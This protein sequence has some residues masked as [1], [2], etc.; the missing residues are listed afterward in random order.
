MR[1]VRPLFPSVLFLCIVSVSMVVVVM[2]RGKKARN[3]RSWPPRNASMERFGWVHG[4]TK[5][6]LR[7]RTMGTQHLTILTPWWAPCVTA[8]LNVHGTKGHKWKNKLMEVDGQLWPPCRSSAHPENCPRPSIYTNMLRKK[9]RLLQ[10]LGVFILNQIHS[11]CAPTPI[12]CR[13]DMQDSSVCYRECLY[14]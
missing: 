2:E 6:L 3:S 12:Y 7:Y 11:T 14:R 13:K 9:L 10:R 8:F 4:G 5:Y 1:K